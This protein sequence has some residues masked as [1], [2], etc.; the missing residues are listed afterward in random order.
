MDEFRAARVIASYVDFDNEVP[1]R[2]IIRRAFSLGHIVCVPRRH[3]GSFVLSFH[4]ITD[5]GE[6]ILGEKGIMEPK[7]SAPRVHPK[8]IDLV[9]VPG[10]GFD[11]HGNRL[12][13]GSGYFDNSLPKM[14]SAFK[15]GLSYE[16]CVMAKL[17]TEPHDHRMDALVTEKKVRRFGK[18]AQ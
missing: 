7:A 9:L 3:E 12:G 17:P 13:F 18:S 10:V 11:R 16:S 2:S 8:K 1:T 5:L 4:R 15:V 14:P 6:L